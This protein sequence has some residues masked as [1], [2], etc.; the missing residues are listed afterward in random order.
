MGRNLKNYIGQIC[1]CWKVIERDLHPTSKSHETFWLSE[2][3]N[4]GNI[5]SVRKTDLDKAPSSC[6]NCKGDFSAIGKIKKYDINPG[7]TFGYL[8]ALDRPHTAHYLQ[9]DKEK[10][11]SKNGQNTAYVKCKCVCGNIVYVR[12][13]NLLGIKC[14]R[15]S[16]TISCG[17]AS[18]SSGEIKT[19]QALQEAG[20]NYIYN[21]ILSDFSRYAPFD[22]GILDKD[23]NLICLL[24][25]DGE[26]H[27]NSVEHFGGEEKLKEQQ[28]RDARKNKYCSDHGIKLKRISYV[29]Y[30]KIT[31]DYLESVIRN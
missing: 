18:K 26:Q 25:F 23:N 5:A 2:C 21:Y 15:H 4:C 27:F 6:N 16:R 14:G 29:D 1:G 24:E 17:C 31:G 30:D 13:D 9:I 19:E 20:L 28:E 8:T 12:K 11:L 7:D 10:K 22:F 3:Q